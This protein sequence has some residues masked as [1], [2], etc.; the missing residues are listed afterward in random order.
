MLN[1]IDDMAQALLAA[2]LGAGSA[3]LA[4]VNVTRA[5]ILIGSA[6]GGMNTF[7]TAIE[8]MHKQA[9]THPRF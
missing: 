5:G 1:H 8:T 6:L 2:G 9:T 4:E 3:E 7:A